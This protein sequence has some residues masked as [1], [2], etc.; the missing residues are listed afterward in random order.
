MARTPRSQIRQNI[1]EIL[2]FIKKGY[3][4]DL[5]QIYK[6]LFPR[7][8]MRSIYYNLKK[9]TELDEFKVHKIKSEQGNYTWGTTAEKIYYELGPE[10][11]PTMPYRVKKWFE[12]NR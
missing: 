12:K 10:A 6:E 4:Y 9:G 5:F 2:Y 7:A 3:G 8:T 11:K 1:V